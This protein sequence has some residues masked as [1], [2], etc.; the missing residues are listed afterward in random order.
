MILR[1]VQRL[2]QK[3]VDAAGIGMIDRVFHAE[4]VVQNLQEIFGVEPVPE[5]GDEIHIL[6]RG[7]A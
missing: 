7:A 2:P 5:A 3:K 1:I 6:L 4:G